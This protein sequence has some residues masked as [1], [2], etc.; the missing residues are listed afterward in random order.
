MPPPNLPPGNACYNRHDESE[1]H[2]FS[3][4]VQKNQKNRKRKTLAKVHGAVATRRPFDNA[5]VGIERFP[6]L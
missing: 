5:G 3:L 1:N 4:E 6:K 2:G